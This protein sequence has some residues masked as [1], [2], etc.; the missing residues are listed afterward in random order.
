MVNIVPSTKPKQCPSGQ[1]RSRR[2]SE[3]AVKCFSQISNRSA[4]QTCWKTWS[5]TTSNVSEI[6]GG[7]LPNTWARS[8]SRSLP[9]YRRRSNKKASSPS[10]HL[11]LADRKT[12]GI[13]S[14]P[15]RTPIASLPNRKL[16]RN[17]SSVK[18]SA[19]RPG[20]A[21]GACGLH[22]CRISLN[23][24]SH[25]S[26]RTSNMAVNAMS[27]LGSPFATSII[28]TRRLM[29]RTLHRSISMISKTVPFRCG[30]RA[31]VFPRS[32]SA[33]LTWRKGIQSVHA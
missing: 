23:R 1:L 2:T 27:K 8:N 28:T 32:S 16:P 15:R 13:P 21:G 11:P 30:M 24:A 14:N 3:K 31:L 9:P 26:A 17:S 5:R 7:G 6:A 20:L 12:F 25:S 29:M 10:K 4:C 19:L 18:D 33:S 22:H